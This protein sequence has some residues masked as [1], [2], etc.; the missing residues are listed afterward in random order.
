M[1][2]YNSKKFFYFNQLFPYRN[3]NFFLFGVN[4][5]HLATVATYQ[6]K[7]KTGHIARAGAGRYGRQQENT[8]RV[9]NTRGL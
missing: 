4:V 5:C 2:V 8:A 7:A 3:Q 9:Q 1:S 6:K